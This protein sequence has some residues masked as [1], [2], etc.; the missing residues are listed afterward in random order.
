MTA[1]MSDMMT[2]VLDFSADAGT[3]FAVYITEE[4]RPT[5]GIAV[6]RMPVGYSLFSSSAGSLRHPRAILLLI[7]F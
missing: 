6:P 1:V 7:E 2:P 5:N 4:L 3:I